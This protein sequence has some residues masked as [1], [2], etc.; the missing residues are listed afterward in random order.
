MTNGH[1]TVGTYV[2]IKKAADEWKRYYLAPAG[3]G[4]AYSLP[5]WECLAAN[6]ALNAANITTGS[7]TRV[8]I[9]AV[10]TGG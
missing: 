7:E 9:E 10:I 4:V 1:A 3:G 8:S 5:S 6:T 2:L